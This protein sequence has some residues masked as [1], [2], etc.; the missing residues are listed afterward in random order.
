VSICVIYFY[1]LKFVQNHTPELFMKALLQ[2]V[3]RATVMVEGRATGSINKGLVALVGVADNDTEQDVEYLA[4]KIINLRIF[5]DSEGKFNLSLT[6]LS[7]DILMVSQFTLMADTRKGRRPNFIR[8]APPDKAQDLFNKLIELVRSKGITVETGEFQ[9]H[10]IVE[11]INN[12]P[13]TIML[14]SKEKLA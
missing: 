12:G 9:Q 14:D 2:R 1:S 4:D 6:D 13:V 7:Y 11:I 8:A 10:M 5:S 3:D